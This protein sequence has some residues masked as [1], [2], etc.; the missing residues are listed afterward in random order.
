VF[1]GPNNIRA[2]EVEKPRPGPGEALMKVTLTTI[3]GTDLRILRGEY[4]VKPGLI[5]L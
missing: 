4:A 3:C 5:R 1:H 2:E